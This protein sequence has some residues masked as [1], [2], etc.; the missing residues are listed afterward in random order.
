MRSAQL[1]S[2]PIGER[3]R[4]LRLQRNWSVRRAAALAGISHTQW[5][6]IERGERS[7]D[8]RFML[9]AIANA[10]NVP[11][12]ELTGSAAIGTDRGQAE[13]RMALHRAMRAV[14]ESDLDDPP[15]V[16]PGPLTPLTRQLDLLIDLRLRCDYSGAAGLIPPLLH[17]LHAAAF[18]PER[19]AALRALVLAQDTAS[20][21]VRYLGDPASAVLVADRGRQ[22]ASALE[23]PV[24]IGLAAWS[25]SHAAAGC[26]LYPRSLRLAERAARELEPHVALPDAQEMLGQLYMLVGFGRFAIGDSANAQAAITTAEELAGR[27]GQSAALGLNFGPTAIDLWRISMHTDGGDPGDAVEVARGVD[28]TGLAALS[29][30]RQVAFYIDTARALSNI[31]RDTEALRMLLLAERTAPQRVRLSPLV[32]ETARGLLEKARRGSGTRELRALCER[33]GVK[34]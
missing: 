25:Q 24:M 6:R 16:E 1:G 19:R 33:V 21:V 32:A 27:T 4:F 3:L 20:F 22:A 28:P 29:R 34:Q 10:L 11:L 13:V 9:A 15:P 18:G 8:N 17:G 30:S 7:A 31:G 2:E 14:I 23:D 5:S 26:G 12:A